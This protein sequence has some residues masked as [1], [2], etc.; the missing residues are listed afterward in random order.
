VSHLD[1]VAPA[2]ALGLALGLRHAFDPD[3]V[4]AVSAMAV[5]ERGVGRAALQGLWWGAG[6][7]GVL[8]AVVAAASGPDWRL[9]PAA[10]PW[11]EGAV[12]AVMVALGVAAA[13]PVLRGVRL[14]RHL[15]AH[16]GAPHEHLHAHRGGARPHEHATGV[17]G[18]GTG[19]PEHAHRHPFEGGTRPLL[20]GALHG[21]AG[22]GVL[23]LL[24]LAEVEHPLA[25]AGAVAGFGAGLA[26]AMA[27]AGALLGLPLRA[28]G[29]GDAVDALRLA[30]GAASCAAGV[31]LALQ[32]AGGRAL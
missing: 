3:H 1:A 21:L 32:A 4:A 14:H 10:G 31:W 22:S 6:H 30:A 23:A 25:R 12:G 7:T 5:G 24:L 18:H 11:L 26:A 29:R 27:G 9:P 16:G 15:H 20:V 13:A 28:G 19:V 2:L 17:P 8:A